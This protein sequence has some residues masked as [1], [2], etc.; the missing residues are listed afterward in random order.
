MG[1]AHTLKHKPRTVSLFLLP[2]WKHC[3]LTIPH[4]HWSAAAWQCAEGSAAGESHLLTDLFYVALHAGMDIE[5]LLS[6]PVLMSL[7]VLQSLKQVI[8]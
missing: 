6:D 3:S 1:L 7:D 5:G 4:S 2:P 8:W